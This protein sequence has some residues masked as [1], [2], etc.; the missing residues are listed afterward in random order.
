MGL[1]EVFENAL[2]SGTAGF[3]A[4]TIQVCNLNVA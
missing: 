1:N 3:K 2:K 4:M